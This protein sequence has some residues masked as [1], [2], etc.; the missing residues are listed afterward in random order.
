M[1]TSKHVV[2][3]EDFQE[4]LDAHG[5]LRELSDGVRDQLTTD[6]STLEEELFET[7]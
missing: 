1:R 3:N 4:D 7:L 2:E 6:S 5:T